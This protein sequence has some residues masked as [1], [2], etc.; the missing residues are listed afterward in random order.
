MTVKDILYDR[1]N[2]PLLARFQAAGRVLLA[3]SRVP[4]LNPRGYRLIGTVAVLYLAGSGGVQ[5]GQRGKVV[6][7]EPE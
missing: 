4:D 2:L 3:D 5:Q 1:E 6:R 7:F